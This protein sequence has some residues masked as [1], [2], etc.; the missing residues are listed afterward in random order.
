MLLRLVPIWA[1]GVLHSAAYSQLQTTSIQQGRA[2]D[3][4][5]L[6][7]WVPPASLYSFEVICAM[8]W[9]LIYNKIVV[10][11]MGGVP[12]SQLQ[13]I[14]MGRFLIF[15]GNVS[16]CNFGDSNVEEH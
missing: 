9:V 8:C 3:T 2:M 1:T 10:P 4:T 11:T 15:F 14:G 5:V 7:F 12:F 6:S 13:R 16:C